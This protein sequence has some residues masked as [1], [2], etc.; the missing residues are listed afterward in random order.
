MKLDRALPRLEEQGK[1]SARFG[2]SRR[3]LAQASVDSFL[4]GDLKMLPSLLYYDLA[5]GRAGWG[6]EVVR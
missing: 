3:T 1:Q 2:R 5:D 6:M 4:D